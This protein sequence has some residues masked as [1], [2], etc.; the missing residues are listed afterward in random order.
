MI[1]ALR[2]SCL[3]NLPKSAQCRLSG[4]GVDIELTASFLR[5]N[6]K[7]ARQMANKT[8]LKVVSEWHLWPGLAVAVTAVLAAVFFL[9]IGFFR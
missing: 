2:R 5:D 3:E 7:R 4:W 8:W 1:V 9:L 6:R